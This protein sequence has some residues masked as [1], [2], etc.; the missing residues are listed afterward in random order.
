[1]KAAAGGDSSMSPYFGT[2]T[3]WRYVANSAMVD[4][5]R[6]QWAARTVPFINVPRE[7]GK[8]PISDHPSLLA[9]AAT[10][11]ENA[12]RLLLARGTDHRKGRSGDGKDGIPG[13]A[14]DTPLH[15]A[16][17]FGHEGC[18]VLLMAVAGRASLNTTYTG[19]TFFS[20]NFSFT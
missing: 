16:A 1:M 19:S 12:V 18:V 15:L 14:G 4:P 5:D 11:D 7:P 9:A 17:R 10:G 20:L 8:R 3:D 6:A 2:G 13:A